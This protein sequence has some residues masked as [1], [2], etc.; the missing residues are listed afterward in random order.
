MNEVLPD[1]VRLALE[2]DAEKRDITLNDAAS[3][4]LGKAFGEEVQLSGRQYRPMADQ[5]KLRV[6]E[7]LHW[8]IRM[9][10]ALAGHTVRGTVLATIANHYGLEAITPTRRPRRQ[11]A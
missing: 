3:E 9:A 2:G 1:D 5:F 8:K 4:I 7:H 10:A 11:T 6:P